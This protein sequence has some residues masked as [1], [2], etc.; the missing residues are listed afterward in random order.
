MTEQEL[1][2]YGFK[3]EELYLN[4]DIMSVPRLHKKY[5]YKTPRLLFT[6]MLR[7]LIYKI[8]LDIIEN[9][10]TFVLPLYFGRYAE[11]SMFQYEGDLFKYM[12]KRG[13][14]KDVDFIKSDFSAYRPTMI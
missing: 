10:V 7:D 2:P 9:N 8:I 13:S 14:F 6:R 3:N 11:M 4:F 5:G 1:S 12:Y